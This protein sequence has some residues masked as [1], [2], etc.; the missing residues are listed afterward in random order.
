MRR[1]RRILRRGAGA[2]ALA[3]W[4]PLS[5][6]QPPAFDIGP[7]PTRNLF[8][9][10]QAP[11]V[12][13]PQSPFL[14][15]PGHWRIDFQLAE[16]N[17][18]EVAIAYAGLVPYGLSDRKVLTPSFYAWMASVDPWEKPFP[19]L[20]YLDEETTRASLQVRTGIGPGTDLW[21]QLNG[22]M[23]S[24]GFLDTL[25]EKA[26]RITGAG[27]W[28]RLN[29]AKNQRV[30]ATSSYGNVLTYSQGYL[31]PKFQDPAIG[32]AH[33]LL[34]T[35]T[36]GLTGTLVVKPPLTRAYA[37]YES[38]WDTQG[39]L[40]GWWKRGTSTFLFGGAYTHRAGGN[41]AYNR[42]AMTGDF[43]AHAGWQGRTDRTVQPYFQL[44]WLSGFST[45]GAQ[46]R[47]H[48]ASLQHDL[49]LHWFIHPGC[50]LTLR[51]VNNLSRAGNTDDFQL[52]V[53]LTARL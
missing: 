22:A 11:L 1:S 48:M 6:Q 34:D 42:L 40:S 49:G 25:A 3:Q 53:A 14:V 18:Q 10:L 27:Q 37:V 5:A 45:L 17:I 13:E 52:A 4:L 33:S 30:L 38:G 51:Y 7:A 19:F 24:G 44:Y 32:L 21:V 46:G 26:H 15:G 20:Y 28:V 29:V 31:P 36:L 47:F 2:L 23:H 50:A 35:T 9:F 39:G 43:G 8:S 12:Y 16:A 41:E